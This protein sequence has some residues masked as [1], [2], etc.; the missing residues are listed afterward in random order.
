MGPV[1]ACIGNSV[2][3]PWRHL[4]QGPHSKACSYKEVD[5]TGRLYRSVN[6]HASSVLTGGWL[7][8]PCQGDQAGN[9]SMHREP[10]SFAQL[11]TQELPCLPSCCQ[12]KS[13]LELL[14]LPIFQRSHKSLLFCE[15]YPFL[16]IG[17]LFKLFLKVHLDQRTRLTAGSCLQ[18]AS[19]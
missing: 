16:N 17:N 2:K 12:V 1:R 8:P 14:A 10:K 11:G 4:E 7:Q 3:R 19:L 13:G 18:M 15:I 6:S 5:C 9:G